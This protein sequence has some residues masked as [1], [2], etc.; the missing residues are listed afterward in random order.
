MARLFA[1]NS[2]AAAVALLVLVLVALAAPASADRKSYER[3]SDDDDNDDEE[4]SDA[5]ESLIELTAISSGA[6]TDTFGSTAVQHQEWSFVS[7]YNGDTGLCAQCS[8][9]VLT[10]FFNLQISVLQLSVSDFVALSRNAN[11]LPVT[12]LV[13]APGVLTASVLVALLVSIGTFCTGIIVVL[14]VRA[15]C[16]S[17]KNASQPASASS[18][19]QQYNSFDSAPPVSDHSETGKSAALIKPAVLRDNFTGARNDLWRL[20]LDPG[21]CSDPPVYLCG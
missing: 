15:L 19:S 2:T 9:T 7:K 12:Y 14:L 11:A 6:D 18:S 13:P 5:T 4:E 1:A 21:V 16:R 3:S 20:A 10:G 17:E 8:T